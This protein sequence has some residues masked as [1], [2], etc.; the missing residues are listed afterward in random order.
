MKKSHTNLNTSGL[1]HEPK[2]TPMQVQFIRD[3]YEV[4][5]KLRAAEG[6][7]RSRHGMRKRLSQMF[8]VS[9]K[10]INQVAAN[11]RWKKMQTRSTD[12]R[13]TWAKV[14]HIIMKEPT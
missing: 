5:K 10:T 7:V 11:Q 14:A 3:V 9:V 12:T 4:D 1:I 8:G 6:R 2:L 13:A